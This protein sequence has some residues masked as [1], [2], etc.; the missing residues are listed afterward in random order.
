M[1]MVKDVWDTAMLCELQ[2]ADWRETLWNDIRTDV[3]EDGAKAFIKEVKSLNKKVRLDGM[4]PCPCDCLSSWPSSA[5]PC[6]C[7]FLSPHPGSALP[8]TQ[9]RDEDVFRGV[10]NAVKNFLISVPLVADL[11]SPAMRDRHWEHLMTA[12]KVGR[13]ETQGGMGGVRQDLQREPLRICGGVAGDL[14]SSEHRALWMSRPLISQ[15]LHM[16]CQ[17]LEN[18]TGLLTLTPIH[19][20]V[21]FNV[22]DPAFK[23]DDLLKLELHKFEEEVGEIV[24][25]AQKEEKMEQALIKLKDI[26]SRVE[27]QFIQFKDTQVCA[28][29]DCSQGNS[30]QEGPE[31]R[32]G[33]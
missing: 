3:M 11:R 4:L 6:L 8:C 27:F 14:C 33:Q 7:L 32:V 19:A 24:D 16:S 17:F 23:L 1:T 2:F 26:W 28:Q 20:Q 9:V 31:G 15:L 13:G 18:K 12:T 5:R 21:N 29:G 22:N 30:R 25:R 10:D